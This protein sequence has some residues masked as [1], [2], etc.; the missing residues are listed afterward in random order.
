M[1]P[2]VHRGFLTS[3]VYLFLDNIVVSGA[4]WIF[5]IIVGRLST[6]EELGLSTYL[7]TL[8]AFISGLL[9]LGFEFPLLKGVSIRSEL[10]TDILKSRATIFSVI[11]T[12]E[13][14]VNL[15]SIPFLAI[16]INSVYSDLS[17]WYLMLTVLIL[18]F[19]SLGTIS[20]YALLGLMSAKLILLTDIVSIIGRIGVVVL[21]LFIGMGAI[22]ILGATMLQTLIIAL[23][24]FYKA[25]ASLRFS[26]TGAKELLQPVLREG[27]GNFPGKISKLMV[28]P[29][30]IILLG[31]MGIPVS[32]IGVFFICLIVSVVVASF[33]TSLA[34]VSL[35]ATMSDNSSS[36]QEMSLRFGLSLTAPI[37]PILV[38]FPGFI[39]SF[40]GPE[41]VQ[42][43]DEL[44]ILS[45]SILPSII[46][47]NALTR[48]NSSND[49]FHL[50]ILGLVELLI[51][52][53]LFI[54]LVSSYGSIGASMA[55]LASYICSAAYATRWI[56]PQEKG[57]FL[58][59]IFSI[60]IG[61]TVGAASAVLTI[62]TLAILITA[63]AT[64][65]MNHILRNLTISEIRLVLSYLT[66]QG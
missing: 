51:F 43:H 26:L 36:I 65:I 24:L 10:D 37:V 57:Q 40:I 42:G 58:K 45:I 33:A 15:I 28:A 14:A 9:V 52:V 48:L 3:G 59:I 49:L 54:F 60:L 6:T 17:F 50:I 61:I 16:Y 55:I 8:A 53:V 25:L 5:W 41:Y 13:I 56:S 44:F 30:S 62:P 47:F 64:I 19:T 38:I 35:P 18:F 31:A 46:V 27:I 20:K 66:R 11:A 63:S 21:M 29:L 32:E 1:T 39:L 2:Y 7:F 12:F 4:G 22:A 23:I 34:T